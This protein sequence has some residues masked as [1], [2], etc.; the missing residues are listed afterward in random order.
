VIQL[1]ANGAANLRYLWLNRGDTTRAITV[2][3]IG[4]YQVV[5]TDPQGCTATGVSLVINKCEPRVNVPD[6]FTPNNDGVND[7]LQVFSSY[8]TDY[9]LR[10][11]NRWGE[12]IFT[13]H[14]PDEKWDGTYKGMLYPYVITYKS[15]SYPERGTVVKRGSVLLVR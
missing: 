2:D 5:V 3:R 15:E 1:V 14:H 6:A 12:V 9:Q 4:Q 10:V 11:Y 7:M 8:I 13:A